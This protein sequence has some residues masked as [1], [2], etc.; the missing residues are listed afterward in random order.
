M[1][2]ETCIVADERQARGDAREY[3]RIPS[4]YRI[5]ACSRHD[6]SR[7][8]AE[9]FIRNRFLRSHGARIVGF[10]PTLVLM[11]DPAGELA[12]VAG[13]RSAANEPLFLE[14][15]LSAPIDEAISAQVS[16]RVRRTEIVEIGNFA[17]IDSRHAKLLMSLLPAYLL[18]GPARWIAFTATAAVRGMLSSLGGHCLELGIAD[19]SCVSGGMD[20]WGRY[21]ENDPRVMAGF[22]PAARRIP[23]LWRPHHGD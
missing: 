18:E 2:T 1:L 7:A 4:S 15:Y 13:C 9:A 3:S 14:R 17:A 5:T 8:E 19:G 23:A 16:Q 20:A 22:L 10:L 12:A 6:A 21:Y 11:S